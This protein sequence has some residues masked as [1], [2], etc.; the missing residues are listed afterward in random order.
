MSH[1]SLLSHKIFCWRNLSQREKW[2]S[3]T[4][5]LLASLTLARIS[6]I[7]SEHLTTLVSLSYV[8]EQSSSVM[9]HMLI[10]CSAATS[11]YAQPFKQ[12]WSLTATS[13]GNT[14]WNIVNRPSLLH[15]EPSVH[16]SRDFPLQI[17]F[18]CVAT[19]DAHS[20]LITSFLCMSTIGSY[21]ATPFF[22][23]YSCSLFT[24]KKIGS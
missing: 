16:M 14:Q 4:W 13:S 19:D 9:E 12:Q 18:H 23:L 8:I 24:L 6:E 15:V 7:S 1:S 20:V 2:R 21:L 5:D 22:T 3:V 10:C 11:F 17:T